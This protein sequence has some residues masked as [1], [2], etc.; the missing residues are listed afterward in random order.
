MQH[1]RDLQGMFKKNVVD[2]GILRNGGHFHSLGQEV[3]VMKASLGQRVD[4]M[5]KNKKDRFDMMKQIEEMT[6]KLQI[7]IA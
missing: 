7:P 2:G 6:E 3:G 4:E 5:E 1:L